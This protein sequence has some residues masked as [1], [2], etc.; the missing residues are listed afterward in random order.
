MLIPN[1]PKKKASEPADFEIWV[2]RW[3]TKNQFGAVLELLILTRRYLES[4]TDLIPDPDVDLIHTG[5][6]HAVVKCLHGLSEKTLP[7]HVRKKFLDYCMAEFSRI[8]SQF[9]FHD[10]NWLIMAGRLVAT[11]AD[12]SMVLAACNRCDGDSWQGDVL[13]VR[14]QVEEKRNAFA[15]G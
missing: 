1:N 13:A 11:K 14:A 10:M 12:A 2:E 4:I 3:N 6:C 15:E 9:R 8:E 5:Q 7:D